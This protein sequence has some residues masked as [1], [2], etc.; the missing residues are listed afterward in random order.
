MDGVKGLDME[1]PKSQV[2]ARQSYDPTNV[3]VGPQVATLKAAGAQVVI[4]FSVPAFTALLQLTSLKLNFN[5]A[6]RGQ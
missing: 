3:N 5:A 6:A 1:I 4:S 2:V